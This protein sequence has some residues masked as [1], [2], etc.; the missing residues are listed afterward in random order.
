MKLHL[1]KIVDTLEVRSWPIRLFP[2]TDEK[3]SSYHH[4]GLQSR[5]CV[6]PLKIGSP[7]SPHTRWT[8]TNL[9]YAKLPFF[10]S[11]VPT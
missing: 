2:T 8:S 1:Y 4:L 3:T 6:L 5:T 11:E 7:Y 10:V 9:E